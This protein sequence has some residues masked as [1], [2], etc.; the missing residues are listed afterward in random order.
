MFIP[1]LPLNY[2]CF[3]RLKHY[4]KR[5]S[6]WGKCFIIKNIF[7]VFVGLV[8]TTTAC[9]AQSNCA[10]KTYRKAHQAQCT[11]YE[12]DNSNTPALLALVGGAALAGVGIALAGTGSSNN[13]G[14]TEPVPSQTTAIRSSNTGINY[15]LSDT[16]KNN[17]I[18]TSYIKSE[19][20]G[21]DISLETLQ[22]AKENNIYNKNYKQFDAVNLAFAT[23]RGFTGKNVNIAIMDDFNYHHG[24]SVHNL[25]QY[26]AKDA[27]IN[28][29][30]FRGYF[31]S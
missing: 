17:K 20:D 16:I 26:V 22:S 19:T 27:N 30:N 11:T 9:L 6:D 7:T 15:S 1:L 29:Y 21:S 3:S 23:A 31:T 13:S 8:F 12:D 18:Y 14:V 5:Q 4:R 2:A 25:A 24:Y 28:N 10:N